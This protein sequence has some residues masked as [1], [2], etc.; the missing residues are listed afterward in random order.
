MDPKAH[1][2][3]DRWMAQPSPMRIKV[4]DP[5]FQAQWDFTNKVRDQEECP[6]TSGV[7]HQSQHVP[8]GRK[9]HPGFKGSPVA[10]PC[11]K[12][13]HSHGSCRLGYPLSLRAPMLCVYPWVIKRNE[14]LHLYLHFLH[15]VKKGHAQE[16]GLVEAGQENEVKNHPLERYSR[17]TGGSILYDMDPKAPCNPDKWMAQPSPVETK[18]QDAFFLAQ[19]AFTN[20]ARDQEECPGTSDHHQ[21]QHVPVGR[22]H[23]PGFKG[24]PKVQPCQKLKK[25]LLALTRVVE[26]M[27]KVLFPSEMQNLEMG[28][29]E[30]RSECFVS[31]LCGGKTGNPG[32]QELTAFHGSP[33]RMRQPILVNVQIHSPPC[34]SQRELAET[35]LKKKEPPLLY[36]RRPRFHQEIDFMEISGDPPLQDSPVIPGKSSERAQ[37]LGAGKKSTTK[38][39]HR[40]KN[41]ATQLR[42]R[43]HRVSSLLHQT[44]CLPWCGAATHEPSKTEVQ[45]ECSEHDRN[46]TVRS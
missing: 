37:N 20:K 29:Q 3:L 9:H 12:L 13:Y 4:Q 6:R 35:K 15:K 30:L 7:H 26:Q 31:H 25:S 34:L 44:I 24:S 2:N 38:G 33:G 46:T 41:S 17:Y 42:P 22:K 43:G 19:G 40:K 28:H 32:A 5:F 18:V 16:W 11:Q 14:E 36:G 8:V 23:H 21:S 1:S 39:S 27:G 10:Q 45:T